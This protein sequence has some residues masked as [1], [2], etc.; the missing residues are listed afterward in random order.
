M[1][2]YIYIL[3]TTIIF[4]NGLLT[5][6]KFNYCGDDG[7]PSPPKMMIFGML[8]EIVFTISTFIDLPN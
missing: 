7:N 5:N 6:G 4:V 1:Y 3:F 8:Y 2:I